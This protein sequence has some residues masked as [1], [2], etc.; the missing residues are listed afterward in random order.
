MPPSEEQ[1]ACAGGGA[2]GRALLIGSLDPGLQGGEEI[3][4][5]RYWVQVGQELT[6]AKAL[7]QGGSLAG[8]LYLYVPCKSYLPKLQNMHSPPRPVVKNLPS[9]A[10][11]EGSILGQGTK[12]PHATGQL[13]PYTTTREAHMPRKEPAQRK[14]TNLER[15]QQSAHT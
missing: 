4:L 3:A 1:R 11:D 7:Q 14:K 13:S 8:S 15:T 10:G 12:I 5:A 9:N 2:S 6:W